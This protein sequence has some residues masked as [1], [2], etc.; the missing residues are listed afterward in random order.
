MFS[1]GNEYYPAP[2]CG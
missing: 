2:L 1:A